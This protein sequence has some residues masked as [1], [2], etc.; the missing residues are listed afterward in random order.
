MFCWCLA[1]NAPPVSSS[2]YDCALSVRLHLLRRL[3]GSV[4]ARAVVSVGLLAF[5]LSQLDYRTLGSRLSSGRWGMFVAAVVVVLV[6]L[7]LGGVRW[8]VFLTVA[9]IERARLEAVRAYLIGAF[10]TNFLPSQV[11][12]DVTRA[13]IVSGPGTRTR[14]LSTVLIDRATLLGCHVVVGWVV[15]AIRPGPVPG[16]LV[17]ALGA[18]SA[19][20]AFVGIGAAALVFGGSRL[21][22]RLPARLD[23]LARSARDALRECLDGS[24]LAR[25]TFLG[26]AFQALILLHVWLLARSIGIHV[27]LSVLAVAFPPVLILSALPISIAGFGVRESGFVLLLGRADVSVSDA[28]LFSLMTAGAYAL[29]TLPGAALL[30]QRKQTNSAEAME[31]EERT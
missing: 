10:T 11:G 27:A 5:V 17:V 25:T 29:A 21:G 12:G 23:G 19:T 9:G 28:T 20:L 7:V 31:S 3:A 24:V 8:H 1:P 4:W 15:Y 14:A 2:V 22:R 13:W 30:L 6:A 26:L 16:S 18:A